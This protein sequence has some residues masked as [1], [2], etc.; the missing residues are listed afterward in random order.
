VKP[1]AKGFQIS[2]GGVF[3]VPIAAREGIDL[4]VLGLA[5]GVDP[6]HPAI[7]VPGFACGR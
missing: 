1:R 6:L 5:V 3:G 7:T 2:L 4:N